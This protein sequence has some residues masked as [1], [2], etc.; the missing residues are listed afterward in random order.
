LQ[1]ADV[2]ALTQC[3][4]VSEA[5]ARA[6]RYELVPGEV[7][8]EQ[9]S[10]ALREEA[11]AFMEEG[12]YEAAIACFDRL[13]RERPEDVSLW[14]EK[15]E[16][17]VLLDRS[18]EAL[19]CY[20]R[21]IDLD[22][23][24]RQAWFERA[25]LLF[26]MGRLADAMDALRECLRIDPAKSDDILLKAEQFRRDGRSNDAAILLQ[27]VLDLDPDNSRAV[28]LLGDALL[29]LG[30]VDAA[31]GLYTRALGKD[32]RN[33]NLLFR[34]GQLLERKGRWGAAIQFYNRAIAL[35][36]DDADPWFAKG[37]I[38]LEHGRAAEALE[39][40]DKV[41]SLEPRRADAWAR[42]ALAHAAVGDADGASRA[43]D[44]AR[45]LG[46]EDP[47]VK[48]AE[49]RLA[50][51]SPRPVPEEPSSESFVEA[52]RELEE[53]APAEEAPPGQEAAVADLRAFVDAIEPEKEDVHVLLQLAEL[54]L[55]GGDAEM[56]LLRYT[57]AVDRDPRN[58]DAWTGKGVALQHLERYEAAIEAYDRAL[59]V[60][61]DHA[62]ATKW[63]QTCHRHLSRG[64]VL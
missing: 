38:L 59:E 17:L 55:E 19:L 43:L 10:I 21:V 1:G 64:D 8:E 52:L 44:R 32:K 56:A 54:A 49:E 20:T 15:A 7:E 41:V 63:R 42:K 33:P 31:E 4:G 39:C 26:G 3:R 47:A 51:T 23:R 22:R 35:Q 11:Q 34:K 45:E 57:Q 9:R 13:L 18:D 36:W 48:A 2:K 30:D 28:L 24:N 40:F 25:N 61:P 16:L 6:I 46:P 27:S 5:L 12:D 50:P 29:D 62:M 60:A 58:A 53:P 37:S 14:F